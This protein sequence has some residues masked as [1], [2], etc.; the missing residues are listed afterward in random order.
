MTNGEKIRKMT[1]EELAE[2]LNNIH[3]PD[4]DKIIIDDKHFY[5]E[6]S[7]LEYLKEEYSEQQDVKD[8]LAVRKSLYQKRAN[9]AYKQEQKARELLKDEPE[10][11]DVKSDLEHVIKLQD[12]YNALITFIEELQQGYFS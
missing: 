8:F 11:E 5:T 6:D 7:I 4:C 9:R 12:R 10:R 3:E 1:N 2:F